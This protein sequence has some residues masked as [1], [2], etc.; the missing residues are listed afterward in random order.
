MNRRRFLARTGEMGAV[1]GG[2]GGSGVGTAQ[3]SDPY[4]EPVITSPAI[5]QWTLEEKRT[6][7][8][9]I[10]EGGTSLGD[11]YTS[12]LIY[13]DPRL[14]ST[15]DRYVRGN[16]DGIVGAFMATR[17]TFDSPLSILAQPSLVTGIVKDRFEA[18]LRR[19]GF[20]DIRERTPSERETTDEQAVAEYEAYYD[21]SE[22]ITRPNS[23]VYEL[24]SVTSDGR[25]KTILYL[26]VLKPNETLLFTAGIRP[27]DEMLRVVFDRSGDA[28]R[29]ELLRLMHSVK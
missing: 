17:V 18:N 21:A 12:T 10:D 8:T 1:I 7:R 11:A 3:E 16:F 15:L 14:A 19:L 25:V 27:T 22:Y 24:P 28:Y 26:E 20:S 5:R 29:K 13:K 23:P 2:I 4:R 9:E 6:D